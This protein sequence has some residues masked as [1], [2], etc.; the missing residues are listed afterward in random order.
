MW[1]WVLHVAA[2]ALVDAENF[3]GAAAAAAAVAAIDT[4]DVAAAEAT[5]LAWMRAEPSHLPLQHQKQP[6]KYES[7]IGGAG[8]EGGAGSGC[9]ARI[10]A[11]GS[12]SADHPR[13]KRCNRSQGR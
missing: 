4:R 12:K 8:R 10:A 1:M 2:A 3:A 5:L 7:T 9:G 6:R 13:G 11:G